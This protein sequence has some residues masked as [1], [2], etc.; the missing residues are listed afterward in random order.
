MPAVE[1]GPFGWQPGILIAGPYG[2]LLYAL[3]VSIIIFMRY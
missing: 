1:P 3:F 2:I